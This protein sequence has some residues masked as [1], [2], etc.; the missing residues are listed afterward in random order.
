MGDFVSIDFNS[1]LAHVIAKDGE[2]VSMRVLRGGLVGQ[3]KAV[4]VERD[5]PMPAF[6][7]KDLACLRLGCDV[8]LSHFA[9]SFAGCGEDVAQL[10]LLVG[11]GAFVISK[12]ESRSGLRNLEEIALASDAL[13]IDRGDLSRQVPIE[14]LPQIQKSVIQRAKSVP[15]RVYVATNL[16]ESMVTMPTPTRAE[17]NDIY[18]T[19]A[20]GADG[21]VLAAET[22]IEI[23]RAHV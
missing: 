6:T 10:R 13:L 22:A 21:L 4:A 1:V 12:I 20:D 23:G 2:C 8:G 16:L 15:C 17:V 19:L 5:I 18:N 3:N 7:E 11:E 9:L 14:L